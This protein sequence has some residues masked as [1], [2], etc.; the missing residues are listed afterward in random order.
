[1][2]AYIKAA[3]LA[4]EDSSLSFWRTS[5]SIL[6]MPLYSKIAAAFYR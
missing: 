4:E 3:V 2:A 5:L 6:A 1:V